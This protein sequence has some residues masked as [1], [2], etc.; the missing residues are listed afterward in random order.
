VI[1]SDY[2]HYDGS[3]QMDATLI[4]RQRTDVEETAKRKILCDNAKRL[5]GL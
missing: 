5:W 2:G 3:S 1:G 4:M